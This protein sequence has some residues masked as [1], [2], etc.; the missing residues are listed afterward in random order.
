M[1]T[2]ERTR[3]TGPTIVVGYDGSTASRAAVTWGV[4]R[5][6][7]SGRLILVNA[8]RRR[9]G[10]LDRPSFEVW[11][12]DRG[13]FG[14][15]LID[16]LVL[17]RDD[18][19]SANIEVEVV[20]DFPAPVLLEAARKHDADEIVI[21]TRHRGRLAALHGSVARELIDVA[22]RPVVLVPA[23]G[24]QHVVPRPRVANA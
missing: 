6:G 20:D 15:A 23:Y 13:A 21:G 14:H 17:E 9:G 4:R 1:T 7:R 12:R 8:G 11:I 24:L 3:P 18:I 19:A 5:A 16:E 10:L 2:S 22:D